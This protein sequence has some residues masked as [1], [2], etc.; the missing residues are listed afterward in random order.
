MTRKLT[1]KIGENIKL[2][3]SVKVTVIRRVIIPPKFT[4]TKLKINYFVPRFKKATK[5]E[6]IEWVNLDSNSHHLEFYGILDNEPKFLF[7]LGTIEPKAT[8]K[9]EFDYDIP[10]IDYICTLHNNEI[11]TLIIYPKPENQMT[12]TDQS[13]FLNKIFDINP[14]SSLSHLR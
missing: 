12:N 5:G 11:G 8:R 6:D 7:D 9:T 13:R 3:E 10:R 14:P 1:R 2:S 4:N